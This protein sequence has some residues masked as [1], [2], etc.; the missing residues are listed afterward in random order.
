VAAAAGVLAFAVVGAVLGESQLL[1]ADLPRIMLVVAG[2]DA[3]LA[4]LGTRAMRW[5]LDVDIGRLP[6]LLHS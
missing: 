4:P 2:L 6:A 3:V 5:A 1:S